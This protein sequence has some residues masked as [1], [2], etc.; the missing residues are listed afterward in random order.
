MLRYLF[1][2]GAITFA[3]VAFSDF[4]SDRSAVPNSGPAAVAMPVQDERPAAR[5]VALSGTERLRA[6][7]R[8]HHIAEFRLNNLRV[9]GLIDTGATTVALNES[10][11][12]RAG[13]RLS[14]GDFIH[15]VETAN[16]AVMAARAMIDEVRVD[17]V[18][19]RDVEALVLEDRALNT[20][21]IGMS[22]MNRLRSFSYENG[23][24]ILKR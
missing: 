12:K 2:F 5:P 10:T 13:I 1:I 7:A 21:L 19:V 20:V 14:P 4:M 11:A 9:T 16:G 6:D 15:R 17:S 18:R 24:L 22:F 3:A 8:G 23:T